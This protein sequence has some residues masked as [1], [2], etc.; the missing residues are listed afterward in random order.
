MSGSLNFRLDL[1]IYKNIYKGEQS[2]NIRS[3]WE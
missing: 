2:V 3:I 1:K